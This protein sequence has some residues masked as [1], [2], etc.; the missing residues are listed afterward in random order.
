MQRSGA[1]EET[2]GQHAVGGGRPGGAPTVCSRERMSFAS[3]SRYSRER[4]LRYSRERALRYARER[5]LKGRRVR[6]HEGYSSNGSARKFVS[7][8]TRV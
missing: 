8:S 2:P 1:V 5:A 7:E 3:T 4:A 6:T